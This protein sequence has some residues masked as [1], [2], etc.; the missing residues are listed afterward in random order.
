MRLAEA[1]FVRK[2]T[3]ASRFPMP[4]TLFAGLLAQFMPQALALF[5]FEPGLRDGQAG[6][7]Q[8]APDESAHRTR[9]AEREGP[10]TARKGTGGI[11][12]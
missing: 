1:R 11:D 6:Q 8:Q 10:P 5:R 9:G 7:H 12:A 3:L 2:A 4:E